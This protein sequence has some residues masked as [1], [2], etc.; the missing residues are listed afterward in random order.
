MECFAKIFVLFVV[1]VV[2]A[3]S[4]GAQSLMLQTQPLERPP[5]CH[6]HSSK[7]PAPHPT[8]SQCCLTGHNTAIP[9][10]S[11]SSVP[12]L[13]DMQTEFFIESPIGSLVTGGFGK[14]AVS[15]GDPP[16]TTPLRI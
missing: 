12:I 10:T 13:Y 9:Q 7:A 14:L 6:E 3:V 11:K 8:S 5:G 2:G 1:T 15:S 4:L 16:G